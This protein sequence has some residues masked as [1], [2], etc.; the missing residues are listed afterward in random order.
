MSNVSSRHTY[1][2]RN[3]Y[4]YEAHCRLG[5]SCSIEGCG[6]IEDPVVWVSRKLD[7][8]G[9]RPPRWL[10]IPVFRDHLEWFERGFDERHFR[11]CATGARCHHAA[12]GDGR[13]FVAMGS[14]RAYCSEKCRSDASNARN[15]KPRGTVTAEC[16]FCGVPMRG[17]TRRRRYCSPN[18]RV[19]ASRARES[20]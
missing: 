16:A 19:Y 15:R 6:P 20:A 3:A 11:T 18:C 1:A 17:V 14:R 13:T 2:F 12:S 9:D 7:L 4:E 5:D 10:P 8:W